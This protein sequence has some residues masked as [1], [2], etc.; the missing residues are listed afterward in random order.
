MTGTYIT[1]LHVKTDDNMV[2]YTGEANI[3]D[4][5]K[6]AEAGPYWI[7]KVTKKGRPNLYCR[8]YIFYSYASGNMVTKGEVITTIQPGA[9]W[10][11]CVRGF[12]KRTE[13]MADDYARLHDAA[14]G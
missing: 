1:I 3:G 5:H 8:L 12:I 11:A 4:L 7:V 10:R 2:V 14:L 13:R 6:I 9:D